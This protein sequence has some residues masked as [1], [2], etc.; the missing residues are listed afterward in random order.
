MLAGC[1]IFAGCVHVQYFYLVLGASVQGYQL[2]PDYFSLMLLC[3]TKMMWREE[4][5]LQAEAILHARFPCLSVDIPPPP[6]DLLDCPQ[7]CCCTIL[8][9]RD[10]F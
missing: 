3:L 9:G 2:V 5:E 7:Q 10:T 1:T 6:R 4:D 8:N